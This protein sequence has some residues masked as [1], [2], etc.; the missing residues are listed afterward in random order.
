MCGKI[1]GVRQRVEA[2]RGAVFAV[3]AVLAL[4]ACSDPRTIDVPAAGDIEMPTFATL[5]VD[6]ADSPQLDA[7]VPR[8]NAGLAPTSESADGTLLAEALAAL[9]ATDDPPT[10]LTRLSIYD[11]DVIIGYY[12]RGV[13]GLSVSASYRRGDDLYVGE[14]SFSEDPAF[15]LSAVDPDLPQRLVDAFALRFPDIAVVSVDMDV[16][17][18]YEFGLC[19]YLR[20]ED[21][22]GSFGN[23]FVD[24]DGTVIAVDVG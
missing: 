12:Q 7:L 18:S 23:V 15:P 16:G 22:R 14:P 21:A 17:L 1:G 8:D 9:A 2:M 5:P 20:L 6:L 4:G 11:D 13:T 19:W 24:P 10:Q 3:V